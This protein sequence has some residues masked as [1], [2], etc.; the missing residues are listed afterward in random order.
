MIDLLFITSEKQIQAKL[1]LI[2]TMVSSKI[3]KLTEDEAI[4]EYI[5]KETLD[6]RK[7]NETL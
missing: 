7:F 6:I 1:D 5:C 3:D 2:G 4:L